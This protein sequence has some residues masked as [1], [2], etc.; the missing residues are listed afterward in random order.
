MGKTGQVYLVGAGPGDEG[1]I[2]VKGM[3]LLK[4]C[5]CIVYDSL[6]SERLLDYGREGC[7]KIYVG[8]RKGAHAYPQ[9]EIHAILI[10]QA[11]LGQRVVRLKGGDPFVFGRGG[12]EVLALQ[13]A[14][15]AVSV[16]PG[17]S[18]ATAVPALAGIPVT[19]RQLGRSLHIF[20]GHTKADGGLPE[21]FYRLGHCGGTVVCLMGLSHL[22]EIAEGLQKQ[23]WKKETPAAVIQEGTLPGQREV[24][25]TLETIEEEVQKAGLKTPAVIVVGE[26]AGLR[27]GWANSKEEPAAKPEKPLVGMIGTPALLKRLKEQ[28]SR[29][30]IAAETAGSLSVLPINEE[31]IQNSYEHLEEYTWLVFTSANG[32]R[33]YFQG[34]FH[35]GDGQFWD[36]RKLGGIKIAVI[37]TGTGLALKEFHL[38]P[39][40]MPACYT[41]RDLGLGLARCLKKNDR[42]LI[43]RAKQGAEE[44]TEIFRDAGV[45]F[46]DLPIYDVTGNGFC[47]E[48]QMREYTYLTFASASGV[49][50][51]LEEYEN[52]R[53]LSMGTKLCCIGE[54]TARALQKAGCYPDC[55][56]GEASVSGLVQAIL[57]DCI[58]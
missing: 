36:L 7:E 37:G 13:N 44:L 21:D 53:A 40:Y 26:T 3:E 16:I 12:E 49:R 15:I 48:E 35:R 5:D 43:P 27:L 57:Q 24:F 10:R 54:V 25:G 42:V 11:K 29:A 33:R 31:G 28:F 52:S 22:G 46:T 56:A 9:E 19:H 32:V 30:G 55:I 38:R 23:G 47:S 2:T 14:G 6:V 41:G 8:K 39:D 51:F 45:R 20:T 1:L 4:T 50:A 58:R 34:F 18:S 17:V